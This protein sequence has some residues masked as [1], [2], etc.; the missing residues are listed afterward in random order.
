MVDKKKT[1]PPVN[2]EERR[3]HPR[4]K[5]EVEVNIHSEHM[6]FTG[7][8]NDI[9][10]GGLFIRTYNIMPVGSE[11]D[12]K[13]KLPGMKEAEIVQ[14]T[15]RWVRKPDDTISA[16]LPI[17]MGVQ[18]QNPSEKLLRAIERYIKRHE[19]MFYDVDDL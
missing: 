18:I 2:W 10:E 17:G 4:Y 7:L 12:I 19:T 6:F 16:D 1:P 9:S 8:T 15:V 11:L 3:R 13:L 14:G 5:F